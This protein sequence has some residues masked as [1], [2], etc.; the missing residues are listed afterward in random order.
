M[1]AARACCRQQEPDTRFQVIS[2]R[3]RTIGVGFGEP[4]LSARQALLSSRQQPSDCLLSVA[5]DGIPVV[6][7][8]A[9]IED[10]EIELRGG[11]AAFG[12]NP[13]V[14]HCAGIHRSSPSHRVEMPWLQRRAHRRFSALK[15]PAEPTRGPIQHHSDTRL[16]DAP[17]SIREEVLCL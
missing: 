1:Y 9:I 15:K 2:R 4:A 17:F 3:I 7:N 13:E 16:G 8:T 12:S 14:L 6:V 5:I 10:T 11:L